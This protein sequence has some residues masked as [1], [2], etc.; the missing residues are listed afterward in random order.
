MFFRSID[1]WGLF[2]VI[3]SRKLF[4]DISNFIFHISSTLLAAGLNR[5]TEREREMLTQINGPV[6]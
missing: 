3:Y 2:A 6:S 5:E 4:I 1:H